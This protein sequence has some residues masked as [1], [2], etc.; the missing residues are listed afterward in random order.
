[1]KALLQWMCLLIISS[2]SCGCLTTAFLV[3]RLLTLPERQS[4]VAADVDFFP[5]N[6]LLLIPA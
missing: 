3:D 4:K 1:M 5:N 6:D 2:A